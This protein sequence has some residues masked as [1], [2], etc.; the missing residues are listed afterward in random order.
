MD[1]KYSK[2][3]AR[4]DNLFKTVTTYQMILNVQTIYYSLKKKTY[5]IIINLYINIYVT[6]K[7]SIKTRI[8]QITFIMSIWNGVN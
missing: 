4:I 1:Q 2:M 7:A 3:L 5:K 8:I 6:I